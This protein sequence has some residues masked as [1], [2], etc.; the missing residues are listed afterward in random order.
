MLFA[1]NPRAPTAESCR[2]L[3]A[4]SPPTKAARSSAQLL[5]MRGANRFVRAASANRR[6][7]SRGEFSRANVCRRFL[8][9]VLRFLKLFRIAR[10]HLNLI[11]LQIVEDQP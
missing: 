3:P 2:W 10:R 11:V 9:H 6:R 1:R 7:R 5:L 8:H 4:M